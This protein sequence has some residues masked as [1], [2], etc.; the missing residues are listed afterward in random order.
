MPKLTLDNSPY[1]QLSLEAFSFSRKLANDLN[2]TPNS[3]GLI[4]L[5]LRKREIIKYHK[6]S[7]YFLYYTVLAPLVSQDT[8]TP[9]YINTECE[10]FQN[11]LK[12]FLNH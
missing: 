7:M 12:N 5:P 3:D 9:V 11:I 1:G 4:L 8:G 6:L 10:V 2:A